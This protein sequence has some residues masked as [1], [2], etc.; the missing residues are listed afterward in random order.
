MLSN[1]LIS[2][3]LRERQPVAWPTGIEGFLARVGEP[4]S[5]LY[6]VAIDPNLDADGTSVLVH[7][8]QHIVDRLRSHAKKASTV[9]YQPVS[10]Y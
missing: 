4:E 9:E 3:V 6:L 1:A 2:E 8:L 5:G 10:E 7:E